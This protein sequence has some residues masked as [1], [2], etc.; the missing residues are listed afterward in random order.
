MRPPRGE[1]EAGRV[2][3][4]MFVGGVVE[5]RDLMEMGAKKA[6]RGGRWT[7]WEFWFSLLI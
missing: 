7:Y 6:M 2:L 5:E 1:G 4:W 3:V